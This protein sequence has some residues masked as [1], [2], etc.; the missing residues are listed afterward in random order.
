MLVE[1][2]SVHQMQAPDDP[3]QVFFPSSIRRGDVEAEGPPKRPALFLPVQVPRVNDVASHRCARGVDV[4]EEGDRRVHRQGAKAD[5]VPSIAG[6]ISV[7]VNDSDALGAQ[8]HEVRHR[9]AA[10]MIYLDKG[11]KLRPATQHNSH[12]DVRLARQGSGVD[13]VLQHVSKATMRCEAAIVRP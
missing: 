7:E 1:H 10:V 4:P 8:R 12:F 3:L 13:P 2:Q 11:V 9:R 6:L 5:P